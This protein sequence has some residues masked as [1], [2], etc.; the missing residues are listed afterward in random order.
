M[1]IKRTED[2]KAYIQQ[3]Y[4]HLHPKKFDIVRLAFASISI[5]LLTME[6]FKEAWYLEAACP[7]LKEYQNSEKY[8]KKV[9]MS[10]LKNGSRMLI[11]R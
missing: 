11:T 9:L 4:P 6:P 5:M 8:W 3:K 10:L 2:L 7:P 1:T